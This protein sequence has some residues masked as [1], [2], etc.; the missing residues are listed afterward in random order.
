M[1]K[2]A[3]AG[4]EEIENVAAT[5]LDVP[6]QT[7]G[8]FQVKVNLIPLNE[9]KP[10]L[11][12]LGLTV[13]TGKEAGART[14][15]T[16]NNP[17]ALKEQGKDRGAEMSLAEWK[18]ACVSTG[19]PTKAIASAQSLRDA[20]TE[21]DGKTAYIYFEPAV[22]VKNS[23]GYSKVTFVTKEKY[24]SSKDTNG[25]RMEAYIKS[26]GRPAGAATSSARTSTAAL[27]DLD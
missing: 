3:L 25:V 21:F 17:Q 13:E 11:I 1:A 19:V 18:G 9:A 23:N 14:V 12:M 8:Y 10:D 20:A 4:F 22:L 27:S 15:K 24:E 16:L 7:D 6:P 26:G 2:N 5:P